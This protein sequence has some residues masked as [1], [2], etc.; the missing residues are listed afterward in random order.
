M[1]GNT[2]PEQD[3]VHEWF[4]KY[5]IDI[6]HQPSFELSN[7]ISQQRINAELRLAELKEAVRWERE[8]DETLTWLVQT[9]QY[10]KDTAGREALFAETECARAAVDALVGEG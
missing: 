2:W 6:A 4:V 3:I 9:G 8:F 7:A 10:P 1:E 5:G